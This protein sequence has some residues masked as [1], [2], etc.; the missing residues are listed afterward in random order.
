MRKPDLK[1]APSSKKKRSSFFS[2]FE[3]ASIF[4]WLPSSLH[5]CCEMGIVERSSSSN[6]ICYRYLV[7]SEKTSILREKQFFTKMI[8]NNFRYAFPNTFIPKQCVP[9]ILKQSRERACP[10]NSLWISG[11]VRNSHPGLDAHDIFW[12]MKFQTKLSERRKKVVLRQWT[13]LE[14]RKYCLWIAK[15]EFLNFFHSFPK[16][17]RLC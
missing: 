5:S 8:E 13:A 9:V 12:P 16:T 4:V 10:I 2:F 11:S 15:K 1:A 6:N 17:L 3:P 14:S 7:S